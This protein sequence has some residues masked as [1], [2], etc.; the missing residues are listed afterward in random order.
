M[1]QSKLFA[2]IKKEI[3]AEAKTI[4]HKFLLRGD[5]IESVASG[6]YSFLPLGWKVHEKIAALVRDEMNKLG[7]QEV[8]LPILQPRSLWG[9]TGRWE[10]FEPP[11]FKFKDRHHKSFALGPTHEEI[12]S[13]MA[14]R[15]I[16][17]Y[18]DL[19]YAVYQIQTKFRNEIRTSG[20]LLRTVEFYMKDLYSFH[21][22]EED[23]QKYYEQVKEAYFRIFAR[24]NLEA[25]AVQ[26]ATGSIG[27]SLS[28]EFMILAETGED[29]VA[30]CDACDFAANTE[31]VGR[32][33]ICPACGKKL[34]IKNAIEQ[35][36]TFNLGKKYSS[37][38]NVNFLDEKGQKQT[39]FMGCYGIGVGR[40][41]ATIIEV[42]HDS[43]GIIWPK[44]A[45]PFDIHLIVINQESSEIFKEADKIYQELIK[46]DFDVLFDDRDN[47]SAGEK[48]AEADLIGIPIRI[49]VSKK[50]IQQN[51]VEIKKRDE[52]ITQ[53]LKISDIGN[54]LLRIT[55]NEL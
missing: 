22:S 33:D 16:S 53:L 20:G 48:F 30:L 19:P 12:I 17:S 42:N 4:S 31:I 18:K 40:L 29:K 41:M 3:P 7:A 52:N 50:T 15:R 13:D 5:F 32:S 36:H 24:C 51:S 9:K 45:S 54:N 55:N 27:G 8:H 11:L 14:S 10:T 38:F 6:V 47:M 25:R 26:A 21:A 39:A 37:V 23:L 49:V 35:G 46:N 2:K 1:L 44:E 34:V 43:K 28:H